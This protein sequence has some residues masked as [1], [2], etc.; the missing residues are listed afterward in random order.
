MNGDLSER[1][2]ETSRVRDGRPAIRTRGEN[3]PVVCMF[4][5]I[6][7]RPHT[8][9]FEGVFSGATSRFVYTCAESSA[10]HGAARA[11]AL[12]RAPSVRDHHPRYSRRRSLSS[13][14]RV[15][16]GGG[17]ATLPTQVHRFCSRYTGWTEQAETRKMPIETRVNLSR[18]LRT[19]NSACPCRWHEWLQ[20]LDASKY[21][22]GDVVP[23][24]ASSEKLC[25]FQRNIVI[26]VRG[27][28]S[29]DSSCGTAAM[30][31]G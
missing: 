8:E 25:R 23:P 3:Y 18:S 6:S 13:N 9:C 28:A 29:H 14:H 2:S 5:F 26:R 16:Q 30:V 4:I 27:R 1:Q 19:H 10:E 11:V 24:K 15:A 17:L 20:Q 31:V 22:P 7:V 21:N 12:E